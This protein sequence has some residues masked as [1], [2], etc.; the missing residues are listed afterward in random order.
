MQKYFSMVK[1][2]VIEDLYVADLNYL[3]SIAELRPKYIWK[4][5]NKHRAI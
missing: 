1:G 2:T 3:D 4:Q 5:P